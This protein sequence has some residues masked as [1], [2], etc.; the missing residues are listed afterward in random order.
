M[1]AVATSADGGRIEVSLDTSA[2][3]SSSVSAPMVTLLASSEFRL[4]V[5]GAI[6]G[7]AFSFGGGAQS[8][9]TLQVNAANPMDDV[10]LEIT[11]HGGADAY[12]ASM[13]QGFFGFTYED[14]GVR[15]ESFLVDRLT[16]SGRTSRTQ[17][18]SF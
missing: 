18:I 15:R 17:W 8:Y 7:G 16:I 12:F 5:V 13:T 11:V 9:A 3:I 10:E 6:S 14:D 1:G 4:D 2:S